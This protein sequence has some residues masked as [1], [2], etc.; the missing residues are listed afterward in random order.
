MKDVER[1]IGELEGFKEETLRRFD[2]LDSKQDRTDEKLES[3]QKF[4]W[5][6]AGGAAVLSAILTG[7]A[8]FLHLSFVK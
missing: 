5:R 8:E 7:V 1:I 2:R 3:L 4:K 6:I